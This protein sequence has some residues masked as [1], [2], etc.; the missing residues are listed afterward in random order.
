M[1]NE[2]TNFCTDNTWIMASADDEGNN[3]GAFF[4]SEPEMETIPQGGR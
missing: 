4:T 2:L 3:G 1:N